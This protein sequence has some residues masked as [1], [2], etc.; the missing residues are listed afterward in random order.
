MHC[1]ILLV[2]TPLAPPRIFG[3]FNSK[4]KERQ[5]P[6]PGTTFTNHYWTQTRYKSK[7]YKC[8]PS[9]SLTRCIFLATG[10]AISDLQAHYQIRNISRGIPTPSLIIIAVLVGNISLISR[11]NRG[12]GPKHLA[13]EHLYSHPYPH[14]PGTRRSIK[15]P[16][17]GS[18][19]VHFP[20]GCQEEMVTGRIEPCITCIYNQC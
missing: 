2:I 10:N 3:F 14:W 4:N 13:C 6:T 9:N 16:T 7:F 1:S 8:Q 5:F 20:G 15:F 11:R 19:N 17:P 18:V 12:L